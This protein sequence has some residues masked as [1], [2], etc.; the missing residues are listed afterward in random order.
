MWGL[1]SQGWGPRWGMGP[2]TA[3]GTPFP[4]GCHPFH[5]SVCLRQLGQRLLPPGASLLPS[6]ASER[7]SPL[8]WG[9]GSFQSQ[10]KKKRKLWKDCR[11]PLKDSSGKMTREGLGEGIDAGGVVS[12]GQC[13]LGTALFGL[14]NPTASSLPHSGLAESL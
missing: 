12:K 14:P 9:S 8:G 6:N 10:K 13:F 11:N 5:C 2:A 1:C 4:G 7:N 3:G